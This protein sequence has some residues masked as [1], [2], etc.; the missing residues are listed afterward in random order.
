MREYTADELRAILWNRS[1]AITQKQ[2]ANE[3]GFR[4][5][6]ICDVLALRRPMTKNLAAA[7]GF[8]ELPPRYVFI[9]NPRKKG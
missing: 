4:A 5:Q 3:T 8:M 6:Y 1:I 2:V 7:L 9:G